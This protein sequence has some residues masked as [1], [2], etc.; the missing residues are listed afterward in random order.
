[1]RQYGWHKVTR[2]L[3]APVTRSVDAIENLTT[4]RLWLADRHGQLKYVLCQVNGN[5]S[6]IHIGLLSLM[7]APLPMKTS[8]ANYGNK[9]RGESLP[10]INTDA[11]GKATCAG[12]VS[13]RHWEKS[14]MK[15]LG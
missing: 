14:C 5:G 7:T 13:L 4:T 12:Y 2:P 9:K 8:K 3:Y 6:S 15:I 10:S 1:M 11:S